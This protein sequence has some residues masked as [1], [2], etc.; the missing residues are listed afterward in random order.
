MRTR[1]GPPAITHTPLMSNPSAPGTTAAVP[2]S[3]RVPAWLLGG[4]LLALAL[5]PHYG[6]LPLSALDWLLLVLGLLAALLALLRDAARP[7]AGLAVAC[8]GGAGVGLLLFVL[9]IGSGLLAPGNADWLGQGDWSQ[10]YL[11]WEFFRRDDWRW[12]PGAIASYAAPVGTSVVYT[13]SLPLLALLLKPLGNLLPET[14]Q[15]VG[16][17]LLFGWLAQ[18]GMAAVLARCAGHTLPA[19]LAVA[20][21]LCLLPML[22]ARAG[23]EAL[24]WHWLLLAAL[25]LYLAQQRGSADLRRLGIGWLGLCA[26]ASLVHPYLAAMVFALLFAALGDARRDG[27]IGS[28]Q[29]VAA[30]A[31]G[32]A[33]LLAGWTLGGAF[34][35]RSMSGLAGVEMGEYSANLL[36]LFDGSGAS[37][38]LPELPLATGGQNEG[39][40]YPGSGLWLLW[41]VAAAL[42]LRDQRRPRLANAALVAVVVAALLFALGPRP[43]VGSLVLFDVSRYT[44]RLLEIFHAAGRFIWLP[45][46]G[47]TALALLR[48]GERPRVAVWLLLA[49]ALLQY[50]ELRQASRLQERIAGGSSSAWTQILTPAPWQRLLA[51]RTQ[52]WLLPARGCGQPAYDDAAL[53]RLAS[54]QGLAFNSAY[55]ARFDG[56]QLRAACAELEAE[57]AAGHWRGD[58][59]YVL[60]DP[61][62]SR[63]HRPPQLQCEPL[64]AVDVCA[65]IGAD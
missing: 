54:H 15:Y 40:A 9:Q 5:S 4:G 41:L 60:G 57:L 49:A 48:L 45:V 10:H 26:V 21:M 39:R 32:G 51:G 52:L 53:A 44:P 58:S 33:V 65:L 35:L 36:T 38:W 25:A 43:G 13:D 14:F 29:A 31:A 62:R 3:A 42:A 17:V 6:S 28:R 16:L 2:A 12:P 22:V 30:V 55:L 50:A 64:D 37:R 11:G 34:V 1:P 23:H 19:A 46:Y 27:R 59:V 8:V 47:L 7:Q 63:V 24:T 20:T 56:K 61:L 18:G